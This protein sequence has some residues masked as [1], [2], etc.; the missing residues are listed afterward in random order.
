MSHITDSISVA[1]GDRRQ[2][3]LREA[4]ADRQAKE[5]RHAARSPRGR[6]G[7]ALRVGWSRL[8][9]GRRA[10]SPGWKPVAAAQVDLR[11]LR[12]D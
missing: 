2:K 1:A 4:A 6:G 8:R 7:M 9:Q 11:C 10:T 5:A 12:A 3:R